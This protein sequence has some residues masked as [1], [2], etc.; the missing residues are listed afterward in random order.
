MPSRKIADLHP[1]MQPL[2]AQF[3]ANCADD[4]IKI[5]ISCTYRSNEEQDQYYASGRTIPGRILT[6]A[7]A[8]ESPHNC[9]LDDGTPAAKAFDFFIYNDD[10]S[11]LDWNAADDKWRAAILIG[12]SLGMVSGDSFKFRDTDHFELKDW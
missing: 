8:G 9:T 2:C 5:G 11:T 7:Q 12:K 1:D 3:I 10:G 6:N 4:G